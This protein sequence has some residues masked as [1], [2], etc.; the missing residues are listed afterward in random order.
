MTGN[1]IEGNIDQFWQ[2]DFP[3]CQVSGDQRDVTTEN[4]LQE[5]IV[6]GAKRIGSSDLY[7]HTLVGTLTSL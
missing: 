3:N 5:K 2:L 7:T 6:I 4:T 1:P